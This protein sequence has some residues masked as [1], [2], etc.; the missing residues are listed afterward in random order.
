MGLSKHGKR[1][2]SIHTLRSHQKTL[3]TA[4]EITYSYGDTILK[5]VILSFS[6][7]MIDDIIYHDV[8]NDVLE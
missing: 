5:T 4:F 7:H 3:L 1:Q 8:K 6:S 2:I